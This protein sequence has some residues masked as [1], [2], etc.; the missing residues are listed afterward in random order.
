[1]SESYCLKSCAECGQCGGCRSGSYALRCGIA[2]CCKEKSHES[3]E[4][5]TRQSGCTVRLGRIRMPQQLYEEDRR[6]S[7]LLQKHRA[8]AAVLGRWTSVVFWCLIVM[9]AFSLIGF[10]EKFLPVLRWVELIGSAALVLGASYGMLQMQS[11][12]QGFRTAAIWE[13]VLYAV[14]L[15]NGE[16][17]DQESALLTILRL[18][19]GTAGFVV[20][21][22]KLRAFRDALCGISRQMSVKWEK[23]WDLYKVALYITLG[24]L[25][26]SLILGILGLLAVV[27][28]AF[29]IVFLDIREYVYLYQTQRVCRD[30]AEDRGGE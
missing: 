23:Q 21:R 30:F 20:T 7:E 19:L 11:V 25:A 3:C 9:N 26:V 15:L 5:C 24:G 27:V 4:S 22:I 12:D 2:Q 1:M 29:M 28:G 14:S 16:L 17:M 8:D 18:G 6:E 13:F 10:L